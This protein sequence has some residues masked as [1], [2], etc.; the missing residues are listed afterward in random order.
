MAGGFH[1]GLVLLC[2][3]G[4]ASASQTGLFPV[5]VCGQALEG[6]CRAKCLGVAITDRVD[7]DGH[8]SEVFP[9]WLGHLVS[10][11]GD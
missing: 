2:A 6:S 8:I 1:C 7:W 3:G 10:F 5:S 9:G 11:A 4:S